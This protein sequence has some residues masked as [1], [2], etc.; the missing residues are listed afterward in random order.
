MK[1]SNAIVFAGLLFL[2][3][4]IAPLVGTRTGSAFETPWSGMFNHVDPID[5]LPSWEKGKIKQDILEFVQ[6]VSRTGEPSFTPPEDRVAAINLD[7]TLW[8]ERPIDPQLAFSV[9]VMAEKASQNE[10]LGLL[11]QYHAAVTGDLDYF[12]KLGKLAA[13]NLFSETFRNMS[14]ADYVKKARDFLMQT[15]HPRFP[16]PYYQA[17][18]LPMLELIAYLRHN[19][20]EVYLVADGAMDF[21]RLFS[22]PSFGI[23][24]KN[25][26]GSAVNTRY[27]TTPDDI[28]FIRSSQYVTP[29]NINDGKP[30]N[31]MRYS[32][33]RPILAAGASDEDLQMLQYTDRQ[34]RASLAI[35]IR[36]DDEKREYSYTG[37][38]QNLLAEAQK[39]S[40]LVVSMRSDWK[41]VFHPTSQ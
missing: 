12:S 33:Q 35:V 1:R 26:I 41:R 7:G 27:E 17:V 23:P 32:G 19:G 38:V 3:A 34:E 5:P 21:I 28:R 24:P 36:H 20:F 15:V 37:G 13:L 22:V 31:F 25:L 39:E 14:Q 2:A 18:Y 9:A 29:I 40:W 11:P 4:F 10:D 8:C 16:I 6:S 30:C